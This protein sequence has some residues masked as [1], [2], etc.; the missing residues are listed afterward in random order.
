MLEAYG[1]ILFWAWPAAQG[2]SRTE[3]KN[4][5]LQEMIEAAIHASFGAFASYIMRVL[6]AFINHRTTDGVEKILYRLAEP[7]IFRSLQ[8]ANSNVC[9]NTLHLLLDMFPL[10]DPDA[11]NEEKDTLLD[12]Q[13]FLLERLL[14]DM[15]VWKLR[16]LMLDKVLA[17]R[18]AAV[19]LLLH[20]K[21][22][23]DF[24][25]NKAVE[26]DV[27]LSVLTSD[28]PPVAQKITK[29]LLPSHFPSK[30]PIEEACNRCVTLVKRAPM[31]GARFFQFAILE[32]ASKSHLMELVKVFLSLILSPDKL[33]ANQINGFLVA[34]SYVCDSLA[35]DVARLLEEC[36][37]VVTNC[38]GLPEDVD[39]QIEIRSAHKLLL[40]LGGFDDLIEA[41]TASLHKVAYR[42]HIKFGVDMPSH[43]VS[44]A[45]R[46][47]S[48]SSGKFSIKSK[49]INRKQSF[50]DDYLV[51]VGVTWQVR[52]LL[53]Q[54]DTR[55]AILES[56]SLEMSFVS[57]K[58]ISEVSIMHC[59]HHE[60][61]DICPVLAYV[62]FAVQMTVDNW[63]K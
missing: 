42:C 11:T 58:V 52:D 36:M 32:R 1:D 63:Q 55:K 54:E 22:V 61:I 49:I 17:I 21:D 27:L 2:D 29:L 23:R 59:G 34:T 15:I 53:L 30:V 4:G 48:K 16:H 31:A 5:F 24:Q 51:A 28:Q 35:Y 57:L 25:F 45:K 19:D 18:V 12:K 9:Q 43:S 26:L 46:K 56:P 50:E 38:S 7:V 33:D 44:F 39:R 40:S 41:L 13:F 3:I 37:G 20:L 47:K 62:A 10:E 8:V 6:E 14:T 60:Y